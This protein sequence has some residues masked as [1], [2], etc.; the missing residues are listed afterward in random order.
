MQPCLLRACVNRVE[1]RSWAANEITCC[2][3]LHHQHLQLI[4]GIEELV[5]QSR[6]PD[7][8][9]ENPIG[10]SSRTDR[11]D[12]W[13]SDQW[14]AERRMSETALDLMLK[15][16]LC[17]NSWTCLLVYTEESMVCK[18]E[19]SFVRACAISNVPSS[20]SPHDPTPAK[21]NSKKLFVC[22]PML[23]FLQCPE[24]QGIH[25]VSGPFVKLLRPRVST[26]RR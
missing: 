21:T 3:V 18:Y 5:N 17:W 16:R 20:D 15:C 9:D 13:S 10:T 23:G 1:I 8:L 4:S 25:Q 12:L 19:A 11:N 6:G 26:S 7:P 2:V 24:L 14:H 22:L